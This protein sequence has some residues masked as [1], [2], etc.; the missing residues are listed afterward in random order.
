VS[1]F[2]HHVMVDSERI[3][4]YARLA[5]CQPPVPGVVVIQHASGV[6]E[7]TRTMVDRLAD[8][9]YAAAAPDLY[10]RLS[11]QRPPL[12]MMKLLRD[13]EVIADVNAV[14][15]WLG[16]QA[17]VAAARLGIIGFCMG[18]RV[19]YLM[20]AAN[21]RFKAA[22]AYYGAGIMRPWGDEMPSPFART[23]EIGCP[24]LF[25]FGADDSN[26][27]PEA[28]RALDDELTRC[29]KPH[30]FYTYPGAGHAFM[31]FTSVDR[32][33]AV[34]S[35]LSWSRTLAFLAHHLGKPATA[36]ISP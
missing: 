3:G 2:T 1:Q 26:P 32:F 21:L 28:M 36:E 6:D 16:I 19:S 18:G 20:A 25:H 7:F 13:V 35:Q 17:G 27:S 4:L 31:N 33:R 15:D 8:A 29:G 34:A 9:G 23:A 30:E 24:L 10:H 12:E 14:I 22:V 11:K 5:A